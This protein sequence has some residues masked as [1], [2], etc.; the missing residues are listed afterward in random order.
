ML[1]KNGCAV[2][3]AQQKETVSEILKKRAEASDCSY[4]EA[5]LSRF[6]VEKEDYHGIRFSYKEYKNLRGSL[7]GACQIAHLATALEVIRTLNALGISVPETAVRKGL[8]ETRWPGRFT[9]LMDARF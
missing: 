5:D 3:S 4:R 6:L 8:E 9:F 2:V 7:A 1:I